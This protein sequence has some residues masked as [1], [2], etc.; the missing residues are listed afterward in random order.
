MPS[1]VASNRSAPDSANR[2]STAP[3]VS[4]GCNGSTSVPKIGPVSRPSSSRKVQAPVTSSPCQMACC[5]GAAPR[6]AGNNEKWRLIQPWVGI[7]SAADGIN[8]P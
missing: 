4:R 6:Q 1:R 7:A 8:P 3:A 2:A 5:T